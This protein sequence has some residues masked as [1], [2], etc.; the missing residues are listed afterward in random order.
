LT[1]K[2]ISH[3]SVA[4]ENPKCPV[5]LHFGELD[6]HREIDI[7]IDGADEV[8]P[9]LNLVKG[10]GGALVWEKIVASSTRIEMIVVDDTKMVEFLCQKAPL[11]V[12]I[13]RYSHKTTARR[14]EVLG[15]EATLRL[16]GDGSPFV[17]DNGNHTQQGHSALRSA[18]DQLKDKLKTAA[19]V[20]AAVDGGKV[21]LVAGVTKDSVDRIKA[22]ELVNFVAQQVGG[23]G[24]GRPDMAQAGGNDPAKLDEALNSV[25]PWVESRLKG[26]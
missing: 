15:C 3:R 4:A 6:E 22:G 24:G 13:V 7:T 21:R 17:T 26:N 8:D 16:A 1:S 19:V 9:Q 11:P 25:A 5:Q 20:L 23:K 18:A 14:L 2:P 12:E 10:L